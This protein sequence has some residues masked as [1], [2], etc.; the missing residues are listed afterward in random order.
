MGPSAHRATSNTPTASASRVLE[1]VVQS[2]SEPPLDLAT[3][4][5]LQI[6]TWCLIE[7]SDNLPTTEVF[8]QHLPY[9]S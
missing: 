6:Y 3:K 8:L 7:I 4:G 9:F 5:D 1:N 2:L